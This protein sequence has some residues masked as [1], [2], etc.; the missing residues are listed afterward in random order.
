MPEKW[1]IHRDGKP[2]A[3]VTSRIENKKVL[4]SL[5]D[6]SEILI[7]RVLLS[8]FP[9]LGKLEILVRYRD[10]EN[11]FNEQFIK[12]KWMRKGAMSVHLLHECFSPAIDSI[13]RPSFTSLMTNYCRIFIASNFTEVCVLFTSLESP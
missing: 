11:D 10:E 12:L 1:Q 7:P 3:K 5:F 2:S 9:S 13:S 8:I 6:E 4:C